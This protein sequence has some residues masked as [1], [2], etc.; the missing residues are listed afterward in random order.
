M[1]SRPHVSWRKISVA[2]SFLPKHGRKYR[3][4]TTSR[5]SMEPSGQMLFCLPGESPVSRPPEPAS[6][7]AR[8][9]TAGS[10]RMLSA[11]LEK[12]DPLGAFSRILLESETWASPEFLLA[13]KL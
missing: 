10:G 9:M 11:F 3:S 2:A 13:W 6:K 7:E 5:P 12:S 4:M 1:E 8:Q